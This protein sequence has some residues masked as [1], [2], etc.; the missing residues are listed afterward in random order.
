MLHNRIQSSAGRRAF[1]LLAL[2]AALAGCDKSSG[3]QMQAAPSDYRARH[4]I[5]LAQTPKMADVFLSGGRLDPESRARVREIGREYARAGTGA[6]SIQLPST[7]GQNPAVSAIVDGIRQELAN[8][9]ARGSV[10]I[11]SY[12][13]ADPSLASPIRISYDTLQA[14]VM[15][16][17]GEWPGDLAS[18]SSAAG[19]SNK[20]Y[21]NHGCAYQQ[22]MAS[23][24]ADP[25]D[26]AGPRAEAI[27]DV[28]MRTRGITKV[29]DGADPATAWQTTVTSTGGR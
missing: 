4:P 17:C 19:W 15:S 16:R 20:P 24:V 13:V 9:G 10:K 26:L 23:Q 5:A 25:R 22:M 1:A 27:S 11:S 14:S 29:R 2:A 28:A 6:V 3:L 18:G 7:M 8:G 12:P 21:W